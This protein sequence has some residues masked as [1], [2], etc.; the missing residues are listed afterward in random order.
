MALRNIPVWPFEANWES[1][2]GETLEW[3]TDILGSPT[4]SEQRRSLRLLPRR[5]MDFS[6]AAEGSE[7]MLLDNLLASYSAQ[8]WYLPL[9]HEV[10]VTVSA[11]TTTTIPC[12]THGLTVG[13]PIFIAGSTVYDYQITEILTVDPTTITVSPALLA[14]P[15][16]GSRV[17]PM[18]SARL[19]EEPNQTAITDS[20]S[21]AEPQ[22]LVTEY[23]AIMPPSEPDALSDDYRGFNVLTR[24]SDWS[25]THE[26]GQERLLDTFDP[27]VGTPEQVDTANR[28]FL[29][30]QQHWIL[31]GYEDHQDFYALMQIMRGRAVPVW[32]PSWTDDM[33]MSSAI[34]STSTNMQVERCG[35]TLSG[36]PRPEREDIMIETMDGQR[37]F[38]RIV[39]SAA[40]TTTE[41]LQLDSPLGV[42]LAPQDV[43]RISFLSLMR[44]D[45]DTIEIEHVTDLD[46][47]SQVSLTF[48]SAPDSRVALSAFQ[49]TQA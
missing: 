27:G 11:A 29:L 12:E 49:E 4:G 34:T 42:A 1:G 3:K 18:V 14:P 6:I 7:R 9:W 41:T 37:F 30:Y 39:T 32:V 15:A 26:R 33:R 16:E 13:M 44:L 23:P 38:R 45:H 35:F 46:G 28:P 19:V 8:E 24:E 40:G 17:F 5:I 2:V 25:D 10:R 48:R 20:L 22:F 21:T 36:G 47:V 31:D 43:L